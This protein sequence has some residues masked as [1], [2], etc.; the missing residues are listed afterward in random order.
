[1]DDGATPDRDH[2]RE[3]F[4]R[5]TKRGHQIE[6]EY[7]EDG[8][9]RLL[10]GAGVRE[11]VAGCVDEYLGRTKGVNDLGDNQTHLFC[12]REVAHDRCATDFLGEGGQ[13]FPPASDHGHPGSSFRQGTGQP[14]TESGGGAGDHRHP[15]TEIKESESP[16]KG[17]DVGARVHRSVIMAEP[18]RP[19][20]CV[21]SGAYHDDVAPAGS[22]FWVDDLDDHELAALDPGRSEP[23]GRSGARPDVLVVGG[24]IVGVATAVACDRAGLGSVLLIEADQLGAGATGGAAGILEPDAHQGTDPTA[25]I[26]LGR[27]SLQCWRDLHQAIPGGVGLE[28]V[29]WIGL[30]PLPD[31]FVSDPPRDAQW[32]DQDAIRALWPDLA[33]AATGVLVRHQGRLNPLRAIARLAGSAPDV[34]VVTG[35][36]ATKITVEGGRVLAVTTAEGVIQPG[37][38]VFATGT[39]PAVGGVHLTPPA[40]WIKGHLLVTE[41]TGVRLPGVVAPLG[42][43]VPLAAQLPDGRLLAGGTLDGGDRTGSP[44]VQTDVISVLRQG[45]VAALPAAAHVRVTHNW[46]CW[47]PHHPDG[48]PVIDRVPGVDNAWVTSGHYRTGVL[49]APGTG[50]ALAEWI[51]TGECPDLVAPFCLARFADPADRET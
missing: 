36:G 30:A 51:S 27:T 34:R 12:V 49:M 32:L 39:M 31:G 10:L 38:V 14:R 28:D 2:M 43:R 16:R 33:W 7:P 9:E 48:Q 4:L 40:G 41:P 44:D 20:R 5:Q 26:D 24:G 42:P 8:F 3:H 19:D 21:A 18:H 25:F 50:T 29:D 46:C 17:A 45:L 11:H 1:M 35:V 22:R 37:A 47:R 15:A 13:S 23:W 6:V